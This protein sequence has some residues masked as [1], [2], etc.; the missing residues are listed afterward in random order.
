M[1]SKVRNITVDRDSF[2]WGVTELDW[3][4]VNIKVWKEENKRIPWFEVQKKFD[5]P[6]INFSEMSKGEIV[7][8]EEGSTPVTP[9]L[10]AAC[11]KEVK[12]QDWQSEVNKPI[13]LKIIKFGNLEIAGNGNSVAH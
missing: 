4:T 10:I 13:Y 9:S 8:D 7:S 2:V 3:K 11:I 6:W 5:D 1:K 12:S